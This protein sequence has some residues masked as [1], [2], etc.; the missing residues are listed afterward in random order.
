MW[1]VLY[2]LH[3]DIEGIFIV[4]LIFII[5]FKVADWTKFFWSSV[6]NGIMDFDIFQRKYNLISRYLKIFSVVILLVNV[7]PILETTSELYE[8]KDLYEAGKYSEVIG[9]VEDFKTSINL[10]TF[11]VN[12]CTFRIST[13]KYKA[14][15]S[16]VKL[17]GGVIRGNG[18]K[19][20][21][22]YISYK[23]GR[24]IVFIADY[25]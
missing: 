1:R 19:V 12:H 16:R 8:L 10:E 24:Y 14:G 4:L 22:R 15:Y 25:R 18:Q 6:C 3:F 21:I 9:V 7:L 17:F 11:T 13:V 5:I 23:G 2:K 20:L